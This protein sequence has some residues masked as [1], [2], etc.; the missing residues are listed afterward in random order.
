MHLKALTLLAF[1]TIGCNEINLIPQTTHAGTRITV[2]AMLTLDPGVKVAGLEM[3]LSIDPPLH[4]DGCTRSTS[5]T[6]AISN[7][8]FGNQ[9]GKLVAIAADVTTGWTNITQIYSCDIIVPSSTPNG[10]YPII[11][12]KAM[13]SD[14][15]G[16]RLL[17]KAYE[18][19]VHVVP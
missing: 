1:T 14:T 6:D 19:V 16:H 4:F 9:Q 8:E 10:S 18:G 12:S 3:T 11:V 5:A 15:M 2:P 13:I 17:L 7:S